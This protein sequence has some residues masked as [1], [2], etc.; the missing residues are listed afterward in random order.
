M[1]QGNEFR[2]EVKAKYQA[3]HDAEFA[4]YK[5]KLEE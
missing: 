2:E 1:T 3:K 5:R 4:E